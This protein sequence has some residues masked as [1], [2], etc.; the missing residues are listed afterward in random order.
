M[1]ADDFSDVFSR[2]ERDSGA[3]NA[4]PAS[5]RARDEAGRFAA[6]AETPVQPEV[7]AEQPAQQPTP[8]VSEPAEQPSN[9]MVPLSELLSER[10][11][12]KSTE[13]RVRGETAK[14]YDERIARLEASLQRFNQPQQQAPQY[15][16]SQQSAPD[17]YTDP[18]GYAA[19]VQE[20]ALAQI[21]DRQLNI[22]EAKARKTYGDDVANQA[23]QYA[24]QTGASKYF[25]ASAKQGKTDDAW[26]DMLE[27]FTKQQAL[28]KVGDPVN[29]EKQIREDERKKAREELIAE[30]KQG[31]PQPKFPGSLADATAAGAQG[32][33]L[34]T[35]AVANDIFDTNRNRRA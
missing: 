34:T 14:Q 23:L 6:K 19:H 24:Q 35:T 32:Q 21:V 12:R 18:E 9:R 33:H 26:G 10:E 8:P 16:Q 11:K 31:K 13:E 4:A 27:W 17:P 2:E 22:S 29:F 28:A 30:M 3:D 7:K 1:S 20:V 25:L 5:D 15:Q